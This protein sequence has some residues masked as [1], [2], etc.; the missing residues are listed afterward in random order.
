MKAI[1]IDWVKKVVDVQSRSLT[2]PFVVDTKAN[3][4]DER[5]MTTINMNMDIK[6]K[7][8]KQIRMKYPKKNKEELFYVCYDDAKFMLPI[9]DALVQDKVQEYVEEN[10][11][12]NNELYEY[13]QRWV[14]K[15]WG[16]VVDKRD[17][18]AY[19]L[20]RY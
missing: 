20:G 6:T 5:D 10:I 7:L 2:I 13:E 16:W 12:L 9:I 15:V 1:I 11:R 8:Y 19:K 17:L 18:I 14:N 3:F 4:I